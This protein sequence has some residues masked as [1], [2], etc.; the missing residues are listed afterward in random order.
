MADSFQEEAVVGVEI[1]V[2]PE[3]VIPEYI[4]LAPSGRGTI[5]ASDSQSIA[6][7]GF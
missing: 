6:S 2:V 4:V 1:V 5:A 7:R 3:I